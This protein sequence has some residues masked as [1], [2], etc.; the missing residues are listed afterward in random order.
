MQFVKANYQDRVNEVN[1]Y[2]SFIELF[3]SSSVD[4]ELN[5]ILKS[6]LLLMLYNLIE[7]SIS[8]AIEEIHNDIYRNRTSY[9]ELKTELREVLIKHL[10]NYLSPKDFVLTINNIALDI[11]KKS[12]DKGRISNGNIDSRKIRELG[13]NYG[14]SSSTTFAQTKNGACLLVIKSR[15]NDLAHGTFSFTEVGKDY[16]IQ[17]LEQMKNETINYLREIL[18]NIESYLVGQE[19][20]TAI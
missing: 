20:K 3:T 8:N 11:V 7:S 5:K 13:L 17:D 1:T 14:F 2:Y 16:T 4:D 19:Y 10:K 6:N 12:F 18:D 15:R 9:D